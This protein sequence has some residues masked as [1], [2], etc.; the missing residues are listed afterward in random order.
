MRCWMEIEESREVTLRWQRLRKKNWVRCRVRLETGEDFLRLQKKHHIFRR[1]IQPKLWG[2]REQRKLERKVKARP[3]YS[4][5]H[6]LRKLDFTIQ[7]GED[8]KQESIM[9]RAVFWKN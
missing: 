5:K 6:R 7:Q 3:P 1:A 9:I 4:L 2:A 8:F